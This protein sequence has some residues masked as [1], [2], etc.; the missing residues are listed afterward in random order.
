MQ[1]NNI[2]AVSVQQ[3]WRL[4]RT[5]ETHIHQNLNKFMASNYVQNRHGKLLEPKPSV[6]GRRNSDL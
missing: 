1:E 4:T 3:P 6:K 2:D 5:M